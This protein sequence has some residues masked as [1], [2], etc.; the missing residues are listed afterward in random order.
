M[1]ARYIVGVDGSAPSDAALRWA[2]R[3]AERDG[4]SLVLAHVVETDAAG[5]ELD[6]IT[7]ARD[8]VVAAHPLLNVS[9][10]RLDGNVPFA[11]GHA[12]T[13]HDTLVV[14][15]H[16]TGFLHGRVLGSRGVL[17]AAAAASSVAVVPVVD[18]RFR[19]GVVVGIDREE[20]AAQLGR[21]AAIEASEHGEELLCIQSVPAGSSTSRAEAAITIAVEA[22]RFA[23][24]DLVIRSRI[25]MRP[26]A[27]V[28]LDAARD[29]ALLMLGPG[30]ANSERSTI[31]SV[32]HTVLLNEN[33]PVL[34]V[35]APDHRELV[36][37]LGTGG[38]QTAN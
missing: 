13:V 16:K 23:C 14:G 36:G 38:S 4:L 15:T 22:A 5:E 33:A 20:T 26:A 6:V 28:L 2:A 7:A 10:V 25:T 12:A 1:G 34:I 35:R 27:E 11:L 24:P 21:L 18:L 32:L 29:K 19:R 30:S 9:T 31:G 8:A 3:R 37:P 17:I